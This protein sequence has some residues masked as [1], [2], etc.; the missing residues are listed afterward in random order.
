MPRSSLSL[1]YPRILDGGGPKTPLLVFLKKISTLTRH[2]SFLLACMFY[3]G[4]KGTTFV[5]S[6]VVNRKFKFFVFSECRNNTDLVPSLSVARGDH[7]CASLPTP[8]EPEPRT[9]SA[10]APPF[11]SVLRTRNLNSNE[12]EAAACSL[13]YRHF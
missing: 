2:T 13:L 8:R 7:L 4:C 11:H 12:K 6:L 3:D 5:C 9:H 10:Q 1:P